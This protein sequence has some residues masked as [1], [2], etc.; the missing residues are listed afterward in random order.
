MKPR[1][2]W[3]V[4]IEFLILAVL[5]VVVP[6]GVAQNANFVARA[7][8]GAGN[9][10]PF[11]AYGVDWH[12]GVNGVGVDFASAITRKLSLRTG[13]DLF[14]YSREFTTSGIP[15]DANVQLQSAHVDLDWYPRGGGF[16]VGPRMV[17]LNNN[18]FSGQ[19]TIP[20]GETLTLDGQDFTG[21]ASDPLQGSGKVSFA[22]ISPGLT[23]G[24]G[25]LVSKKRG[26]WKIPLEAGFYYVGQP[27][28]EVTF[29]GQACSPGD[30]TTC[31]NVSQDPDF[32]NS[33]SKFIARQNH[34]LSYARFFPILSVGVGYAF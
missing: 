31:E 5:G 23:I 32:Q 7:P 27:R 20:S 14:H 28:L 25:N 18:N 11:T 12:V 29:T 8:A 1:H 9:G 6:A 19:S 17:F 10:A 2:W 26:H 3:I 24:Y 15:V 33:L 34:N 30:S 21:S 22:P 4:C 13:F 16:H